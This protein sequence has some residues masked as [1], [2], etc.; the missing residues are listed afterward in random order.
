MYCHHSAKNVAFKPTQLPAEEAHSVVVT[1]SVSLVLVEAD[2]TV[3]LVVLVNDVSSLARWD[4]VEGFSLNERNGTES[5]SESQETCEESSTD[6]DTHVP[7]S[8]VLSVLL[9][10]CSKK[11][12]GM[13][14]W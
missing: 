7:L 11:K 2:K 13:V 5:M 6:V 9:P 14:I 10:F 3:V 8:Y 12:K 4:A 1:Q